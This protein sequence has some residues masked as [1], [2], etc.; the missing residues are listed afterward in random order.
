MIL[1]QEAALETQRRR[2]KAG[3][4]LVATPGSGLAPFEA[5]VLSLGHT[6]SRSWQVTGSSLLL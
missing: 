2:V 4:S 3:S 6:A 1:T 5:G